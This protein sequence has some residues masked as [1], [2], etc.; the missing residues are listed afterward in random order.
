MD[1]SQPR[2]VSVPP[3]TVK[4]A[5]RKLYEAEQA[6][7]RLSEAAQEAN[8]LKKDAQDAA[9]LALDNVLRAYEH[10]QQPM[11]GEK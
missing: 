5:T 2:L 9:S 10:E 8:R 1:V 11:L 4:Q 7:A 6:F 3:L